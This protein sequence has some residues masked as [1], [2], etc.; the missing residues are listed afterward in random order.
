[1]SLTVESG[2]LA[3]PRIPPCVVLSV[4]G[5]GRRVMPEV[6]LRRVEVTFANIQNSV[7]NHLG[8][9]PCDVRP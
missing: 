6:D 7:Q 8:I 9:S 5:T 4:P 2:R 3:V 1:M